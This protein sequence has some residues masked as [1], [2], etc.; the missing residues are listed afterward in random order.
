MDKCIKKNIKNNSKNKKIKNNKFIQKK[1]YAFHSLNEVECF[2]R[3]LNIIFK[4]V[5]IYHIL[6]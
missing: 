4:S 5:K 1:D 6:K 2:L 3:N